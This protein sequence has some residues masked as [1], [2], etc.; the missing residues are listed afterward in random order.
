MAAWLASDQTC[1]DQLAYAGGCV[2]RPTKAT[3][4]AASRNRSAGGAPEQPGPAAGMASPVMIDSPD[5]E[6][7]DRAAG[8]QLGKR[9]AERNATRPTR[10]WS[11]P[12][13]RRL[14][15]SV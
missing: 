8:G 14:S 3:R 11:S 13:C 1:P 5:K 4:R 6:R 2:V 15:P 7:E 10:Y 9:S 12:R